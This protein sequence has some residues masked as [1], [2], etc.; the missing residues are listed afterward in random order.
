MATLPS[1]PALAALFARIGVISFGGVAG[2]LALMH[3]EVVTRRRWL[4]EA[5]YLRAL[6]F[7]MLLPGPEAQQ[8]ATFIGWRLHGWRGALV[9]GTLFILPGALI[10]GALS[11]VAAAHGEAPLVAALFDGVKPVVVGIVA[12]ALW[13]LGRK[14]LTGWAPAALAL[15]A[16]LALQVLHA[17]FPLV[18]I[19]AGLIGFLAGRFGSSVPAPAEPATGSKGTVAR[20]SARVLGLAA[21]FVALWA[22]PVF[23]VIALAG[24]IFP[25]L[26]RLFTTSAFVTF[27]GA[28]AVL[29]YIAD[30]AVAVQGWLTPGEMVDGLALAETTPGPTILVLEFVGFLAAWKQPGALEPALAGVLGAL[31]VTYVT[32]LPSFLF[33]LAG[34]PLIEHLAKAPAAT[35]ALKAITAAVVGVMANLAL[36]FGEAVLVPGGAVDW[37][38]VAVAGV[39]VAAMLRFNV[40]VQWLVLAG[41]GLGLIGG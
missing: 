32:F 14:T 3:D 7:C 35:A 8:L 29:P 20:H 15:A 1:L 25:D 34:S 30:Q 26:A 21:L 11:W 41:A 4:D 38:A 31:L 18:V 9:T 22:V 5:T 17:P 36:F 40:G 10:V 33:I 16:L 28:Y 12:A 2:Q 19:G 37:R 24:G 39:T 23:A 13:R 6:N 27:G